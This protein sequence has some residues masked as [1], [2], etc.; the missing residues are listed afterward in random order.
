MYKVEVNEL[1][2]VKIPTEL[3][4]KIGVLPKGKVVIAMYHNQ[5]MVSRYVP[6]CAICSSQQE[7]HHVGDTFYCTRCIKDIINNHQIKETKSEYEYIRTVDELNRFVLPI[8]YRQKLHIGAKSEL[9]LSIINEETENPQIILTPCKLCF[10][11][12][13]NENLQSF[14]DK[15]CICDKCLN[16]F[17]KISNNIS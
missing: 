17:I 10:A 8:E 9:N 3:I 16:E 7:V 13:S 5:I 4:E 2:M 6:K 14:N 12:G 15:Y 1:G 11:C